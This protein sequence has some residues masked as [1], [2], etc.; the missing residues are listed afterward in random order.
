MSN[1]YKASSRKSFNDIIGLYFAENGKDDQCKEITFQ[2]TEDCC[3]KCTY[4]YQLHK[5]KAK[6]TFQTAKDFIDKLLNDQFERIN[7]QNTIGLLINFIGG[8][9]L[10]EIELISQ[11]AEYLID[12]MIKNNHPWLHYT[13]FNI[14][15]NGILYF[16]PRVQEFLRKFHALTSIGIS[17]DGNK[18]LHD[19]CRIDLNGN[20]SYDRAIAAVHHYKDTYGE[21]PGIKMTLSPD[22][23]SYL[24]NAVKNLLNEGYTEIFLNCVYEEGWNWEHAHI[25]YSEMIK[26]SDY[27][28]DRKYNETVY[29]SLFDEDF[30]IPN[31]KEDDKNWCGGV[32]NS[33]FAI[34]PK[35]D[36]YACIRYMESS[37]NGEQRP[38]KLG[39]VDTGYLSTEEEKENYNLLQ[40][41]TKSSQ[42]TQE[43][44]NCPVA[45]GCGWC[46]GYNYQ[47]FGT[48]NKRATFIC[49]MHK[50]RALANVYYWNKIYSLYNIDKEF[51][52][53]LSDEDIK[54][55][56]KESE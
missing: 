46:S 51:V 43:C 21:M 30:F 44:L 2:I 28:I 39:S 45:T 56:K 20:G 1:K 49:C 31:R 5:T 35:G 15:T 54:L 26:L 38:L 14:G 13:R 23:I 6:M 17:I 50:A 33:M 53:Y 12:T 47:K 55:I 36:Y 37:L 19:A 8:E 41:I 27:I 22:N 7:T 40:N 42:S 11:I 24:Y 4:C 16:D 9:P 29:I 32:G 25:L 3:L 10:M 48:P 34:D 18:E 52:N